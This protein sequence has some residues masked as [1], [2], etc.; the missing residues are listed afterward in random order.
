MLPVSDIYLRTARQRRAW[1]QEQLEAISG[2]P[3]NVISRLENDSHA[4]PAW[5]TVK[6]LAKALRLDPR[7]LR[8]GAQLVASS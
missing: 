1:T 4:D 8:F 5:S 2:V 6:K 7:R 3:Q